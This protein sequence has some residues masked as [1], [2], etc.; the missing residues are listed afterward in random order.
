MS[1]ARVTRWWASPYVGGAQF[2]LAA[3]LI[4]WG[5]YRGAAAMNYSWQWNRIPPYLL[6]EVDGQWVLGRLT[7]GL[8]VTLEITAESLVLA[9]LI[10]L[11]AAL[12]RLSS[13]IVGRGLARVYVEI[14]R[15]TPLLVQLYLFYFVLAPVLGLD[16]YLVG[17]F[18]LALFEGAYAS[19]IIRA[20]ILAV[21]RGQ[22]EAAQSLGLPPTQTYRRVILPQALRI[23][24]P[25]LASQA[26][27]L[28][29][30]SAMVSVIAVFDLTNEGRDI[31]A[32]TFMTFEVW[33]TVAALY[34]IVTV[35]L[36]LLVSMLER[37]VGVKQ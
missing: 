15:S 4:A 9:L 13:S 6:R 29:K 36:S 14:I 32:E 33:L 3:A 31:I 11:I 34:L 22:W 35:T 26:I 25:P 16:R 24:L 17:I 2:A 21:P 30:A 20:G 8:L 23:V 1:R 12:L 37:M 18:A 5:I 27:A 28:V 7:Q 10:G 19:E